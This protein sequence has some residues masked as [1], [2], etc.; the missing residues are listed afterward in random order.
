MPDTKKPNTEQPTDILDCIMKH[1]VAVESAMADG[2]LATLDTL[3]KM[4]EELID[5]H[6]AFALR[7]EGRTCL[8]M[9]DDGP[10]EAFEIPPLDGN[11]GR[12]N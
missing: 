3:E 7:L 12:P 11:N 1:A 6:G 10:S 5:V 2:Q 9:L 8:T 4:I